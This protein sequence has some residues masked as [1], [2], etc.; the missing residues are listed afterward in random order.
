MKIQKSK[1]ELKKVLQDLIS[2]VQNTNLCG[3]GFLRYHFT[4]VEIFVA[5]QLQPAAFW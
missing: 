5:V 3:W 4:F 1:C 2:N